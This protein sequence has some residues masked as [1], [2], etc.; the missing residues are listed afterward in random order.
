MDANG[1]FATSL[2]I[3]AESQ[4]QIGTNA[5]NL[6]TVAQV[7]V[8]DSAEGFGDAI[9]GIMIDLIADYGSYELWEVLIDNVV[10]ETRIHKPQH[11]NINA[12]QRDVVKIALRAGTTD[13]Y[14]VQVYVGD[15]Q[16]PPLGVGGNPSYTGIFERADSSAIVV[17]S[18]LVFTVTPDTLTLRYD[19]TSLKDYSIDL[20]Q[21]GAAPTPN[22]EIYLVYANVAGGAERTVVAVISVGQ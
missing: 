20:P 15:G 1:N 5:A 2:V 19:D 21:E 8:I 7:Y 13:V 11:G 9:Y 14:D 10:T 17:S 12:A 6:T 4:S 16:Y 22:D 18:T 3:L